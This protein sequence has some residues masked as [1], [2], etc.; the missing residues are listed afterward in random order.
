MSATRLRRGLKQEPEQ[1]AQC[2]P[3]LKQSGALCIRSAREMPRCWKVS[4]LPH[5]CA[6]AVQ[7]RTPGRR[8]STGHRLATTLRLKIVKIDCAL[9]GRHGEPRNTHGAL[10]FRSS[11]RIC[12]DAAAY[13][14]TVQNSR[15]RWFRAEARN[16]PRFSADLTMSSVALLTSIEALLLPSK[17]S[18]K[19]REQGEAGEIKKI[20]ADLQSW[21]LRF[22]V[23]MAAAPLSA[24]QP[25][26][27]T[28]APVRAKARA[29][30]QYRLR[31]KCPPA[32]SRFMHV[33]GRPTRAQ[34]LAQKCIEGFRPT[35]YEHRIG[36]FNRLAFGNRAQQH[37]MTAD[38]QDF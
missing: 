25:A 37:V 11:D 14:P 31:D 23:R 1:S 29:S 28:S 21:K 12:A 4:S 20:K 34:G 6:L 7:R 24:L 32:A 16:D 18:A 8:P 38:R 22:D 9:L 26:T 33:G 13:A 27:I 17:L 35:L 36:H 19:V 10:P 30:S 3:T 2:R 5:C 15:D